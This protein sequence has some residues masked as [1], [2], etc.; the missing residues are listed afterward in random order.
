MK[1]FE[2]KSLY[3][4]THIDNVPSILAKGIL[5][6]K[7]IEDLG[8]QRTPIYDAEIVNNRKKKLTPD[9]RSLW[10]YANLYFQARN[11]MMYRVIYEKDKSDIAIIGVNGRILEGNDDI[12]ITTGNA[13]NSDT[14]VL[15]L[16]EGLKAVSKMW[17]VLKSEWWSKSDGSKRKIMAECLVPKVISNSY[18]DTIYVV[19]SQAAQKLESVTSAFKVPVIP[20]PNLFFQPS[21][22]SRIANRLTLAQGDMF[23]SNMQT[24]TVSVNTVGIMGKGLA[25]RA[26]YQFPD[27]YVKYQDVCRS[28]QL[29]IGKPYL[30]KRESP[31][32]ADLAD[33]GP[34]L[35]NPNAKKWFLLFP[36]KDHWRNDSK[37]EYIESGLMWLKK[38]Y[39]NLKISSIAMPALG[40]GL[41]K[42]KWEDVG[43]LMCSY[44][45]GLDIEAS[46]YLPRESEIPKAL[47]K[48]DFLL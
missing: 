36:T 17:K 40:C 8:I 6:H 7:T 32:D 45:S 2:I 30:Y 38:H 35:Q 19:S 14:E 37:I 23:F 10:E 9:N 47:L 22:R 16:E 11:P 44:L 18:I 43:P 46:I 12:F 13:A 5:S 31:L 34:S 24:L 48:K 27:L 15:P 26:K 1:S 33:D 39:K 20:E 28:R 21:W 42:L 29:V 3:Y 25:S 41:G 4:I